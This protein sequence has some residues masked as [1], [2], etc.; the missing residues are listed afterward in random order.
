MS[1][2]IGDVEIALRDG[3]IRAASA[4]LRDEDRKKAR[5][6]SALLEEMRRA[7][8]SR[9]ER[10]V[11]DAAAGK[12]YAGVLAARLLGATR[13]IAIEREAARARAIEEAAGALGAQGLQA[14]AADVADERVWPHAPAL[15]VALHACGAA[16]D[17]AL[18]QAARVGARAVLVVPCCVASSLPS[19]RRAV[20]RADALGLPRDA[21]VRRPFVE[22]LV[23]AERVLALEAAGYRVE[24]VAMVP[25]SVSPYGT[26]VRARRVG[27]PV[28]MHRAK[29]RLETLL[30]NSKGECSRSELRTEVRGARGRE[31]RGA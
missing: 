20:E 29:E 24:T 28:R 23:L 18:A 30:R 25:S 2:A 22:S 16:T 10:V 13:V 27:E 3:W 11:V 19:S 8:P 26:L 4:G 6:L 17:H 9:R 31:Q 15:V 21:A 5:E 7:L 1:V 12:G 14:I